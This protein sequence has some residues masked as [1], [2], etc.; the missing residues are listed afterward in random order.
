MR[1]ALDIRYR[2]AGGAANYLTELVPRLVA[3]SRKCAFVL[4]CFS[5]Q[6]IEGLE[7][8]PRIECAARSPLMA[9]AWEQ[10][11]LPLRL[12]RAGI[13]LY[14]PLKLPAA[15]FVPCAAARMV[16]SIT[17]RYRGEFP[18]SWRQWGY[19]FLIGHRAYRRS[20]HLIACSEFLRD[21]AVEVLRFAP[22]RITVIPY[23]TT[24]DFRPLSP[25]A[26]SPLP[27]GVRRPFVLCVG[28]L[29]RVK[30]H[31]TVVRA[32]ARIAQRFDQ[33]QLVLAGGT[34]DPHADEIRAEIHRLGLADRVVL[35]GFVDRATVITLYN[36]CDVMMHPSLTE[37]MGLAVLEAMACGAAVIAS[38]TG[39]IPEAVGDA[40]IL[41]DCFQDPEPWSAALTRLLDHPDEREM[42]R[43]RALERGG[44]FRYEHIAERVL[45]LY[46]RLEA[47]GAVRPGRGGVRS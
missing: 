19:W 23:G 6:H 12:R 8:L 36:A 30:N 31:I 24:A 2:T 16:H 9:L 26:W 20:T 13:D 1:I 46:D 37:G 35:T 22:E 4:V 17:W 15:V 27:A 34:H 32:F 43:Q 3:A 44:K 45:E 47:S 11:V 42:L 40:G 10:L 33:H 39:G 38:R 18:L 29:V 25:E 14:H 21:F 41:I 5:D 7:T 28:N